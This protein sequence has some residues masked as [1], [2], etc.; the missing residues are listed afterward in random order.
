MAAPLDDNLFSGLDLAAGGLAPGAPPQPDRLLGGYNGRWEW[1]L[2]H[3]LR[4]TLFPCK[5]PHRRCA[6][7]V[8][9]LRG[10]ASMCRLH[11]QGAIRIT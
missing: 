2:L 10:Q 6:R 9:G 1:S 5:I 8:Q 7:L 3:I 11:L 4:H